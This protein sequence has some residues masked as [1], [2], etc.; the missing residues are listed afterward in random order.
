MTRAKLAHNNRLIAMMSVDR[1]HR[2]SQQQSKQD[3]GKGERRVHQ[4]HQQ[5]VHRPAEITGHDSDD[6]SGTASGGQRQYCNDQAHAGTVDQAAEDITTERIGAEDVFH[7]AA[8]HPEWR[9]QLVRQRLIDRRPGCEQRREHRHQNH[10]G[11][12]AN[13]NPGHP[14]HDRIPHAS[15]MR[16]ST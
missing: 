16:G 12:N 13:R 9:K 2:H 3:S 11:D 15:R 5:I 14:A 4:P 10:G 8:I 7:A 1:P 6:E